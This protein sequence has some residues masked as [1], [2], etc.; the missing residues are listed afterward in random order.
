MKLIYIIIAVLFF[1]V[2][3]YSK[4]LPDEIINKLQSHNIAEKSVVISIDSKDCK[5][6]T[7]YFY[8]ILEKIYQE[9]PDKVH[10]LVP[11]KMEGDDL[12]YLLSQ[13]NV[14]ISKDKIIVDKELVLWFAKKAK[15]TNYVLLRNE[16]TYSF[17]DTSTDKDISDYYSYLNDDA[18]YK[19]D[20]LDTLNYN[21]SFLPTSSNQYYVDENNI[22]ALNKSSNTFFIVNQTS[23]QL[24]QLR[25]DSLIGKENILT[26]LNL[27]KEDHQLTLEENFNSKID[28]AKFL[29]I[30]NFNLIDNKIFFSFYVRYT[31]KM[32][33]LEIEEM[34]GIVNTSMR[35]ELSKDT[36]ILVGKITLFVSELDNNYNVVNT[37]K[38][39]PVSEE[40]SID[41]YSGFSV[42]QLTN[43]FIFSLRYNSML[44]KDKESY[45][46]KN[47]ACAKFKIDRENKTISFGEFIP[48][49]R[50]KWYGRKKVLGNY[51]NGKFQW[52]GINN[53]FY[54]SSYPFLIDLTS[55]IKYEV[56]EETLKKL[57]KIEGSNFFK[58]NDPG[59]YTVGLYL[60]NDNIALF[61]KGMKSNE[62]YIALFNKNGSFLSYATM[63]KM[64]G[65]MHPMSN[66]IYFTSVDNSSTEKILTLTRTKLSKE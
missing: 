25:L 4:T 15:I 45:N 30:T 35:K 32:N 58:K 47:Y 48:Q 12:L 7:V 57:N 27:N 24:T 41:V 10:C 6:C 38:S 28:G 14:N 53:Y 21:F 50:P 9:H 49:T 8:Q 34:K 5:S 31:H 37:Y 62:P 65:I 13:Q 61:F 1:T 42:Y 64:W 23:R 43:E 46:K 40:Y 19:F 17:L 36:T 66:Y 26:S 51:S 54:L 39:N 2:E 18:Q 59:Y 63:E 55:G 44:Y 52:V 29:N 11:S 22:Y 56:P 33:R 20:I 60:L 3:G 16:S